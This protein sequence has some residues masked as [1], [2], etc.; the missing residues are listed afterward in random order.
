ME[1]LGYEELAQLIN[2]QYE[3]KVIT[4]HIKNTFS[5]SDAALRQ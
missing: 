5:S 1:L 4:T 2:D 3:Q